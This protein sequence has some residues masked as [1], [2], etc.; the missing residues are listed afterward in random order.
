M[1]LEQFNNH[2][3]KA[4]DKVVYEGKVFDVTAVDFEDNKV[5]LRTRFSLYE[6]IE[7]S[8]IELYQ[9]IHESHTTQLLTNLE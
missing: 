1:T 4:T 9:P 6:W 7:F 5:C 8:E 2:G 3:W